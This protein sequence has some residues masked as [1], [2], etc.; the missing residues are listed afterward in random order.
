MDK[1]VRRLTYG[2]MELWIMKEKV[3]FVEVYQNK[4]SSY[5]RRDKNISTIYNI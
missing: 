5:S 3:E 4:S 1:R 2:W